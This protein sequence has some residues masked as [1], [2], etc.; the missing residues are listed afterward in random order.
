MSEDNHAGLRAIMG[1]FKETD[2]FNDEDILIVQ[3]EIDAQLSLESD[4]EINA[5]EAILPK[6]LEIITQLDN[7]H[8]LSQHYPLMMNKIARKEYEMADLLKQKKA[9]RDKLIAQ[10]RGMSS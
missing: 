7:E 3:E 9:E 1:T 6:R 8:K 2:I 4:V 5:L 10:R